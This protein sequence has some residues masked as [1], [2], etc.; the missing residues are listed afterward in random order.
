MTA[1]NHALTGAFI[2]FVIGSPWLAVPV[3]IASH[4]VCDALPHYGSSMPQTKLLRSSRFRNYLLIEAVACALIVLAL[5]VTHSVH[6]WLAALCAFAAASPDFLWI[7]RYVRTRR[8]VAW[9]PGWFARFAGGI[10]WFQRPI[11][12]VVEVGWFIGALILLGP[13]LR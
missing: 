1:T 7:Q 10:Q 5:G 3:A 6:W 9:R 13:F 12:A 4:F 2:G 8:K 11:G